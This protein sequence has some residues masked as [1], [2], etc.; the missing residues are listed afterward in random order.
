MIAVGLETP[1]ACFT[2]DLINKYSNFLYRFDIKAGKDWQS[3][4]LG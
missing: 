3:S 2:K 4:G 1:I